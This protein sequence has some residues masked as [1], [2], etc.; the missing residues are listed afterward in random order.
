MKFVKKCKK[1]GKLEDEEV[2]NDEEGEEQKNDVVVEDEGT[3]SISD[4]EE[5]KMIKNSKMFT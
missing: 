5:K 3:G 2:F 1:S 4:E